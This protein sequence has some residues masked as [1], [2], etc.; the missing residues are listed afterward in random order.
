MVHS[1]SKT[2]ELMMGVGRDVVKIGKLLEK[3]Q[4]PYTQFEH[5]VIDT[6]LMGWINEVTAQGYVVNATVTGRLVASVGYSFNRYPYNRLKT[7]YMQEWICVHPSYRDMGIEQQMLDWVTAMADGDGAEV[8]MT[9][10]PVGVVKPVRNFQAVQ[11]VYSRIKEMG[12]GYSGRNTGEGSQPDGCSG[13]NLTT[14]NLT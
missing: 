9:T 3:S 10:P 7:Y 11:V 6:N 5:P 8:K 12:D 2:I 14:E 1:M 4:Y 13:A